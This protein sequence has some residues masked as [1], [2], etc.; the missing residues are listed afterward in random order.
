MFDGDYWIVKDDPQHWGGK[1]RKMLV[2]RAGKKPSKARGW[3][4][5]PSRA[6]PAA[7]SGLE[8]ARGERRGADDLGHSL[9]RE[10]RYDIALFR[11]TGARGPRGVRVAFTHVMARTVAEWLYHPLHQ[12]LSAAWLPATAAPV[13]TGRKESCRRGLSLTSDMVGT[14]RSHRSRRRLWGRKS[15]HK[16]KADRCSHT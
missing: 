16:E 14:E 6:R 5:R 13:A 10:N 7:H 2:L 8:A 1:K 11:G 12:R 4:P 9:A 3:P 15:P